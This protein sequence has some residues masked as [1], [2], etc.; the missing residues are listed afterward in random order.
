MSANDWI[1]GDAERLAVY[2][3][4]EDGVLESLLVTTP[5]IQAWLAT[6]NVPLEMAGD[7]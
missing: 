5:E 2:R 3:I 1:W 7:A 4:R 6:G